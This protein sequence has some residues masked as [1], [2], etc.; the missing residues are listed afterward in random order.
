MR[1][2]MSEEEQKKKLRHAVDSDKYLC[3]KVVAITFPALEGGEPRVMNCA[4]SI[5]DACL[6]VELTPQNIEYVVA[7]LQSSPQVEKKV[8]KSPRTPKRRKRRHQLEVEEPEGDAIEDDAME[9]DAG[10][11]GD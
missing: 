8:P 4:W 1:R 2:E 11:L 10:G 6:E 9:A 5:K 7:A 3:G